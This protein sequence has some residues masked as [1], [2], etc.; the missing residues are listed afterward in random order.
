MDVTQ[1]GNLEGDLSGEKDSNADRNY[2]ERKQELFAFMREVEKD[3]EISHLMTATPF[4]PFA[5][6]DYGAHLKPW[7]FRELFY[8]DEGLKESEGRIRRALDDDTKNLVL[9]SG[10]QGCG[11]TVF[12]RY[13]VDDFIESNSSHFRIS[14]FLVP[15]R[16]LRTFRQPPRPAV[17]CGYSSSSVT[18]R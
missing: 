7:M 9:I 14:S 10:Y 11:K 16:F 13:L 5:R 4:S 17:R 12:A 15:S 6:A 8:V 1:Y 18:S 2:L 3:R